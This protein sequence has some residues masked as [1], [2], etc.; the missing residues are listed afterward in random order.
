MCNYSII[1]FVT[2]VSR[3]NETQWSEMLRYEQFLHAIFFSGCIKNEL[4]YQSNQKC[5]LAFL[6][7]NN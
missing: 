7:K 6:F 2:N 3:E 4:D 5:S 1:Q